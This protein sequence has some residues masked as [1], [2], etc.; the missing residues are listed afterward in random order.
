MVRML[1]G[2]MGDGDNGRSSVF[3]RLGGGVLVER[4]PLDE[5]L[6][7]LA[8]EREIVIQRLRQIDRVL[9]RHGRLR[10]VTLPRRLR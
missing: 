5:W 1:M 8:A 7:L 10:R 2:Q 3:V 4:P 9:V 6:D